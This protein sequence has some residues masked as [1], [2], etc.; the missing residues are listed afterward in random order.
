MA[1]SYQSIENKQWSAQ[2]SITI[3][4]LRNGDHLYIA[5]N[6]ENGIPLFQSVDFD[7][8]NAVAPDWGVNANR[9]VIVPSVVSAMGAQVS[10][11]NPGWQYNG[12]SL[13]FTGTESGGWKTDSTGKFALRTADN[14]I[15]PVANL[16]DPTHLANGLLTFTCT[17]HSGGGS[18]EMSKGIDVILQRGGS[19][20]YY[21]ALT[22][23]N[24]VLDTSNPKSTIT[25]SLYLGGAAVEQFYVKWLR[26][27]TAMTQHNGKKQIE[28]TRSGVDGTQLYVAE[29][30]EGATAPSA[31]ATPVAIAGI[32]II[33]AADIYQVRLEI[34]S[35]KKEISKPGDEVTVKASLIDTR[36]VAAPG[37]VRWRLDV[38]DP[39]T[40]KSVKSSDTD[41]IVVTSAET[42]RT[43]NGVQVYN[44]VDVIAEANWGVNFEVMV[45]EQSLASLYYRNDVNV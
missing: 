28:A 22:A 16:A 13:A 42:D 14:A 37:N 31:S 23:T 34:T 43:V 25:A 38:L 45:S 2:A 32:T 5:L 20:G 36:G 24:M 6:N 9:P 35:A 15:K 33:D 7:N 4:R 39:T 19:S 17:A 27:S 29:F 1:D 11:S 26:D 30:Y 41:T 40:F 3:K 18:Y 21:G 10:I 12:T 44:D 8:G